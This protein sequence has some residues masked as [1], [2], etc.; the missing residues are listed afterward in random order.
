MSNP[1]SNAQLKSFRDKIL[2]LTNKELEIRAQIKRQYDQLVLDAGDNETALRH[3]RQAF[4][5]VQKTRDARRM[6][7]VM[8]FHPFFGA[9]V[10]SS[11]WYQSGTGEEDLE[12]DEEEDDDRII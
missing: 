2:D 6:E 1:L 10:L 8:E 5:H 3:A 12:E 9:S 11:S 4:Y 7:E